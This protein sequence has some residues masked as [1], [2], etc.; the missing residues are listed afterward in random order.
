MSSAASGSPTRT[1][2]CGN[3]VGAARTISALLRTNIFVEAAT[4]A[5]Y[6]PVASV[7]V[8]ASTACVAA[9]TISTVIP[10]AGSWRVFT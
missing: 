5:E 8:V 9:L 4:D 3:G 10:R 6:A 1:R 7:V 2:Q